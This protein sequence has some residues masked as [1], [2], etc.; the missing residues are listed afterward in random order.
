MTYC[1]PPANTPYRKRYKYLPRY[2]IG[3]K[4]R[5]TSGFTINPD[6]LA[7]FI[8]KVGPG[9]SRSAILEALID[10]YNKG[11]YVIQPAQPGAPVTP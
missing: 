10:G 3:A 7:E 4:K 11:T 6:I 8:A 2:L 9:R 5:V 1:L